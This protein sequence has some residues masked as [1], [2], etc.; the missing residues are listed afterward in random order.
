MRDSSSWYAKVVSR[1]DGFWPED[2]PI[3]RA[4]LCQVELGLR[5]LERLD[6]PSA[7]QASTQPVDGADGVYALLSGFPFALASGLIDADQQH[8]ITHARHLLWRL[9][10]R[11]TWRQY[12]EAYRELPERLRA[13][14]VAGDLRTFQ[15]RQPMIA[16]DRFLHYDLALDTMPGLRKEVLPIAG[17][18]SSIFR[19]R[20]RD[21][22][23]EIPE[24]L[25]QP[26]SPAHDLVPPKSRIVLPD[27]TR[28]ELRR[29]AEWMD[30]R[31]RK[32]KLPPG[33]WVSRLDDVGLEV[34]DADG[35]CYQPSQLLTLRGLTHL[36]GMVGAGKSTLMI[37]I[38]VW[39][40]RRK[41]RT[42]IVVGDVAEQLRLTTLFR[43]L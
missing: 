39:A 24:E 25:C 21:S 34:L 40:A 37:L 9:R 41:L 33:D 18:G 3:K 16:T 8:M 32:L 31:E 13:Y 35:R 26:A 2:F 17:P 38:A 43:Y 27:V 7:G 28:D 10:R 29:T 14:D 4:G 15:R 6:R 22:S 36:V 42:T 20:G 19:D 23:V 12:L 11:R 5:L 1:F 30:S